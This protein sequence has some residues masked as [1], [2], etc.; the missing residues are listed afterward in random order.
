MKSFAISLVFL[1]IATILAV[2]GT[3]LGSAGASQLLALPVAL[4]A[5][6]ACLMLVGGLLI[7]EFRRPNT[8]LALAA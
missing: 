1:G 6:T 8:P 2:V 5:M 4:A 7:L 3:L